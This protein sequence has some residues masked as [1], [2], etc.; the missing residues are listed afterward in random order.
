MTFHILIIILLCLCASQVRRQE[1]QL[2][3]ASRPGNVDASSRHSGAQDSGFGSDSARIRIVQ[4]E[5]QSGASH[6]R[7]ARPSRKST[8]IKNLS[9]IPFDVF[10]TASRV[11]LMT[12]ACVSSPRA[13]RDPEPDPDPGPASEK[14]EG[15]RSGKSALNVP[16]DPCPDPAPAP[17]PA[18]AAASISVLTAE[19][20]LNSNEPAAGLRGAGGGLLSLESLS[21]PSRSSARQAL[22]ITIV[23][24]PGRRGAGDLQLEPLLYLQVF[25]PSVLLSC[26]HRKQR[27]ELSVFDVALKGVATDYKCLGERET[28]EGLPSGPFQLGQFRVYIEINFPIRE[29]NFSAFPELKWSKPSC[30]W[31]LHFLLRWS[32]P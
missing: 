3:S 27:L 9:F 5:Q 12:Y 17:S 7:I 18:P 4:I 31:G 23:R 1:Q 19:D 32:L 21:A 14:K 20:L 26:H 13:G 10:V 6:H 24:Q 30:D 25:Q 29:L 22:G 8:I 15:E 2:S 16:G 28:G 11:S